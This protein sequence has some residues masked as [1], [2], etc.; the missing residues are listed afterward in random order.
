M[1]GCVQVAGSDGSPARN[2]DSAAGDAP[3]AHVQHAEMDPSHPKVLLPRAEEVRGW[4]VGCSQPGRD[5]ERRGW[6]WRE[7]DE[8]RIS[9]ASER[10][11]HHACVR[12]KRRRY[13]NYASLGYRS[14]DAK[15]SLGRLTHLNPPDSDSVQ[16]GDQLLVLS[17]EED[18]G[19]E[20]A[21]EDSGACMARMNRLALHRVGQ[22]GGEQARGG[23]WGV[24]C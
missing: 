23:E 11:E 3:S 20:R 9:A 7:G 12:V 16:E 18:E 22:V 5:E 21:S 17:R 2:H 19:S 8:E 6:R 15:S 13:C 4:G 24:G 10:P 14:Q 1:C